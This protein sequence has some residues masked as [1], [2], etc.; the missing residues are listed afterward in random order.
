M[1]P[2][3]A[4]PEALQ[5]QEL[6]KVCN[7]DV[8]IFEGVLVMRDMATTIKQYQSLKLSKP[9]RTWLIDAKIGKPL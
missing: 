6:V 9:F 4:S 1:N 5:F 7:Q 2:Q 3:P 8:F